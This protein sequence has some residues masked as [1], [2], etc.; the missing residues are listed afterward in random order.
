MKNSPDRLA[1]R[2]FHGAAPNSTFSASEYIATDYNKND[3]LH[4]V[5]IFHA[6]S[7]QKLL[8]RLILNSLSAQSEYLINDDAV[9]LLFP[10]PICRPFLRMRGI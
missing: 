1:Y 6:S 9:S 7:S 4:K 8:R 2:A 5:Y 10:L 3:D